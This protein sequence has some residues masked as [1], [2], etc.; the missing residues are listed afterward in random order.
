M[1]R[2]D[3]SHLALRP[4]F[5]TPLK[6]FTDKTNDQSR[7]DAA[8]RDPA[9]GNLESHVMVIDK[10]RPCRERARCGDTGNGEKWSRD[11]GY[12]PIVPRRNHATRSCDRERARASVTSAFYRTYIRT[13]Y[14]STWRIYQRCNNESPRVCTQTHIPLKLPISHCSRASQLLTH[15]REALV[16][17]HRNDPV[18]KKLAALPRKHSATR[19]LLKHEAFL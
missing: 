10:R 18:Q 15:E 17:N 4:L 6:C 12:V 2:R 13:E 7:P 8:R 9:F 11:K 14:R 16:S 1:T 19:A 5:I 3:G